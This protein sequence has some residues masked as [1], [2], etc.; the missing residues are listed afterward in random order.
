MSAM[1]GGERKWACAMQ[2]SHLEKEILVYKNGIIF[3]S[4]KIIIATH[5]SYV[6]MFIQLIARNEEEM[7]GE[8]V[9]LEL[10]LLHASIESVASSLTAICHKVHRSSCCWCRCSCLNCYEMTMMR[11][12]LRKNLLF[13]RYNSVDLTCKSN[14][15]TGNNE[16]NGGVC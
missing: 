14:S 2:R 11:R 15:K 9:I 16:N 7:T 6:N 10:I 5:H 12:S 1:G 3:R 8:M 4:N 13:Q